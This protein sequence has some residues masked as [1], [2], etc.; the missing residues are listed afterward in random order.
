ML[1]KRIRFQCLRF[2]PSSENLL[3][4]LSSDRIGT[5]YSGLCPV[6]HLFAK[7][8]PSLEKGE[9]LFADCY[10][11]ARLRIPTCVVLIFSYLERSK[12]VNLDTITL[13]KSPGHCFKDQ[14]DGQL[15]L[16]NSCNKCIC[17]FY[18]SIFHTRY[19]F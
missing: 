13:A 19:F 3:S 14:I 11:I 1:D 12:A 2:A 18:C 17:K 9:F 16:L 10:L 5:S 15:F 4:N 8:L 6:V 7:F